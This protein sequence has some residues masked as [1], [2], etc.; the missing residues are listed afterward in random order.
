MLAA[1]FLSIAAA[2]EDPAPDKYIPLTRNELSRLP[3]TIIRLA[4]TPARCTGPPGDGATSTAPRPATTSGKPLPNNER[5]DLQLESGDYPGAH[6]AG[7]RIRPPN[8]KVAGH[9]PAP[10]SYRSFPT[11]P[12]L[13]CV[14]LAA[15]RRRTM[16]R[17]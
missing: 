4:S 16:S 13:S 9:T 8:R 12:V 17:C 5:H 15:Q 2:T 7:R 10:S 11:G 14:E 6:V 1:A 3:T